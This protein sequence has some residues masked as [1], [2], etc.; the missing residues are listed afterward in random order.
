MIK[1]SKRL[2]AIAKYVEDGTRLVDVGCD[3]G[4][5]D[6]YLAKNRN[7]VDIIASD[8]NQ[9]ALNNAINNIKKYNLDNRIKTNLSNGL[10][11]VE[12]DGVDTL[13][14]SGMGSH[15][16]VGILY[17]N[18]RKLKNIETLILQSNNDLDFLRYKVTKIGYFIEKESLVKDK[19]IIYTIIRF[20]K[21]HK[22]YTRKQLYFGPCLLRENSSLFK[23]KKKN[24]LKK[25]LAFYPMIPKSHLSH[26]IKTYLKIKMYK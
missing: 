26:R 22:Y 4:L 3:H 11:N 19:S 10:D 9:N 15:T 13:I 2:M 18:L 25:L 14:I 6:I 17:S 8:I 5:L 16:I 7:N 24:E 20:K 23:E 1:L 21:G 12:I